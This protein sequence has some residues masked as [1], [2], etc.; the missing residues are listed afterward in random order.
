MS[1]MLANHLMAAV[2]RPE[3]QAQALRR[4][5]GVLW[6][7]GHRHMACIAMFRAAGVPMGWLLP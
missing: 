5:A 7:G 4:I 6:R 3:T 2:A 1:S